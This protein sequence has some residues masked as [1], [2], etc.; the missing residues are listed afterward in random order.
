VTVVQYTLCTD[1]ALNTTINLGNTINLAVN[2][3]KRPLDREVYVAEIIKNLLIGLQYL[4]TVGWCLPVT[5]F[6]RSLLHPKLIDGTRS[7]VR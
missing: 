3:T 1:S 7:T 4:R 5:M 2:I 6:G